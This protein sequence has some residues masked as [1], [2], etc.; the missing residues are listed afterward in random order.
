MKMLWLLLVLL[1]EEAPKFWG[2]DVSLI[3]LVLFV[4]S[5]DRRDL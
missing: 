2:W 4:F 5:I 3:C 1:L